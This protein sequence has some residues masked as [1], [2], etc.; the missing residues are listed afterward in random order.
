M[1]YCLGFPGL[2]KLHRMPRPLHLFR[3][4]GKRWNGSFGERTNLENGARGVEDQNSPFDQGSRGID[5]G[6]NRF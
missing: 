3:A 6:D 4:T 5:L 1:T 2:E